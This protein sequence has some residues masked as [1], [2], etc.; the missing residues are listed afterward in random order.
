MAGFNC[1]IFVVV[2]ISLVFVLCSVNAFAQLA[3]TMLCADETCSGESVF[4]LRF[5]ASCCHIFFACIL[6]LN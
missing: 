2:S 6:T 5:E 1:D 4:I 3:D